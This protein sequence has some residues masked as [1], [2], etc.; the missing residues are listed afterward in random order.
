MNKLSALWR[1][2]TCRFYYLL[3]E[4]GLNTCYKK[5]DNKNLIKI[6]A[7]C[8]EQRRKCKK[9]DIETI[10]EIVEKE[11]EEGLIK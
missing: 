6:L 5:T 1:L 2:L 7:E 4:D 11:K 9:D 3:T 8:T 10:A